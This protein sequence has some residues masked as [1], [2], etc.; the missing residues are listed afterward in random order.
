M[1][2]GFSYIEV[3]VAMAIW[4]LISLLFLQVALNSLVQ[5][6]RAEDNLRFREAIKRAELYKEGRYS[7]VR[8]E[9]RGEILLLKRGSRKMQLQREEKN[10]GIRIYPR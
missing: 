1:K 8:W 6:K 10:E 5:M 9:R 2:K 3:L 4:A 7:G